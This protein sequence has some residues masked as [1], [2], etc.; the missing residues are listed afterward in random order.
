MLINRAL[1]DAGVMSPYPVVDSDTRLNSTSAR[2]SRGAAI[3]SQGRA[4]R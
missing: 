1:S 3:G 2:L 4:H